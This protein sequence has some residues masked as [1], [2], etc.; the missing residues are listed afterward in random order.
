MTTA[1]ALSQPEM[2]GLITAMV[3]RWGSQNSVAARLDIT[4]QYLSDI[5]LGRREISEKVAEKLGYE[6]VVQF[7]KV[8]DRE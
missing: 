7:V 2:L 6:R 5:R 4:P 3:K 8:K 1:T